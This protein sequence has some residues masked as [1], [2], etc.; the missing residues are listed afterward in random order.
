MGE[1]PVGRYSCEKKEEEEKSLILN[2]RLARLTRCS[3]HTSRR[4]LLNR[5]FVMLMGW[6]VIIPEPVRSPR[7]S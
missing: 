3:T 1:I 2:S 4:P 7:G 6:V 5:W